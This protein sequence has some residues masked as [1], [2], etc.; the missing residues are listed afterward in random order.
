MNSIEEKIILIKN[1]SKLNKDTKYEFLFNL[2][3]NEVLNDCVIESIDK[4]FEY[5]GKKVKTVLIILKYPSNNVIPFDEYDCV[6]GINF[7]NEII[8]S[9]LLVSKKFED[10]QKKFNECRELF[11]KNNFEI[12]IDFIVNSL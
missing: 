6:F 2:S 3:T 10:V 9:S 8:N 11:S 1:K 7:N 12:I 5:D 4:E